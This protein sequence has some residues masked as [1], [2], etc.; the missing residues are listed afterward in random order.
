MTGR[1]SPL[2]ISRAISMSWVKDGPAE[3]ELNYF[4][5]YALY[6]LG[7]PGRR[8]KGIGKILGFMHHLAVSELHDTHREGRL[9]WYVM[10]TSAIQRSPRPS[11]RRTWKPE[12]LAG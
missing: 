10:I 5:C 2:S 7:A 8:L 9:P 11:T 1:T 6:P 4:L 12:G 3:S